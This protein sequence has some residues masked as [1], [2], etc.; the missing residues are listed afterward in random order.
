MPNTFAHLT[1]RNNTESILLAILREQG[2]ISIDTG[3]IVV[4][5]GDLENL[6]QGKLGSVETPSVDIVSDAATLIAGA[7]SISITNIGAAEGVGITVDGT[8]IAIG[9]TFE[10][11]AKVGNT[12]GS[13]AYVATGT[14]FL[15]LRTT[16]V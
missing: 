6:M 8:A 5:L 9:E 2:D 3:D 1:A 15:I 13:L 10:F 11:S 16:I 4:N 14:S 7:S 12:L